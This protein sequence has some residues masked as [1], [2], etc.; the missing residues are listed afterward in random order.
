MISRLRRIGA[1]AIALF[2]I[3]GV[4]EAAAPSG[5]YTYAVTHPDHGNI[6]T[7]TNVIRRNG[8]NVSVDTTIRLQV[9][10]AFVSVFRLEADRHEE[11]SGKR[12]VSYQSVTQKNG[13]EIRVNGK[14]EGE[15]FVI[16]GSKGSVDAPA[17]IVP[18]NPWTVDITKAKTVMASESGKVFDASLVG[19]DKQAI[20]VGTEQVPATHYEVAA[21]TRYNLWF[22]AQGRA[23]AFTTLEDGKTISFT[24]QR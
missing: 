2:S 3:T 11:W 5:T 15:K 7:Y 17:D 19:S 4:A 21:D 8:D 10:V 9:K 24:L 13:K 22:D 16:E 20:T 23:V 1:I 6:G 14:A 18:T 12:L